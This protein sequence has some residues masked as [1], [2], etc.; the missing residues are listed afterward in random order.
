[1]GSLSS[2][3]SSF[4][5][6]TPHICLPLSRLSFFQKPF[7]W[8]KRIPSHSMSTARCMLFSGGVIRAAYSEVLRSELRTFLG[9]VLRISPAGEVDGAWSG[10]R[11]QAA[12]R[13][14]CSHRGSRR[15]PWSLGCLESYPEWDEVGPLFPS[16]NQALDTGFSL[17][18]RG[19]G[20]AL[21]NQVPLLGG[22]RGSL[23]VSCQL[24]TLSGARN[25]FISVTWLGCGAIWV[26]RGS[27]SHRQLLLFCRT[28]FSHSSNHWHTLA[29]SPTRTLLSYAF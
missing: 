8:R 13:S 5:R 17:K 12:G 22:E 21:F 26:V 25:V 10:R 24:S 20:S 3:P 14:N 23:A 11:R 15:T 19:L 4:S 18:E 6:N 1:M 28:E 2:P 16:I 29:L 27:I 7:R 9:G